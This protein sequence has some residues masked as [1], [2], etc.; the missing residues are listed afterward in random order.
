MYSFVF[1]QCNNSG[2]SYPQLLQFSEYGVDYDG[3]VSYNGLSESDVQLDDLDPILSSSDQELLSTISSEVERDTCED[4]ES[5][6]GQYV[7]ACSFIY[8]ASTVHE[9]Q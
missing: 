9:A 2:F 3:P 5:W 7:F 1:W 6:L 8:S 4:E